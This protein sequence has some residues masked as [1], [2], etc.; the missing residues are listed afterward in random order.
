VFSGPH[1]DKNKFCAENCDGPRPVS[2][3]T[4]TIMDGF[5]CAGKEINAKFPLATSHFGLIQALMGVSDF[6]LDPTLNPT[7]MI[8]FFL[9]LGG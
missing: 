2:Q 4:Y 3:I 8:Y 6:L 7:P 9:N 5:S 1:T